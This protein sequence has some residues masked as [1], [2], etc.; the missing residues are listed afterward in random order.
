MD[1]GN[2]ISG[3]RPKALDGKDSFP[4]AY[5]TVTSLLN[6]EICSET[7]RMEDMVHRR[8]IALHGI[9]PVLFYHTL[10]LCI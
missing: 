7:V 10:K 8:F 6:I 1:V 2:L 4:G 5:N 9:N 3:N